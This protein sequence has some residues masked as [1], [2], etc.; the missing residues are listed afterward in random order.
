MQQTLADQKQDSV[1]ADFWEMGRNYVLSS[2]ATIK[3]LLRRTLVPHQFYCALSYKFYYLTYY[4]N[5][6]I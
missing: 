1:K 5:E 3:L 6:K 2:G 4:V